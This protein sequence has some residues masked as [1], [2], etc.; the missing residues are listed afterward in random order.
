MGF[1]FEGMIEVVKALV[2]TDFHKSMTTHAD[3]RIWPDVYQPSTLAGQVYLK[4]TVI[5]PCSSCPLRS[6]EHEV[7]Y[8][9]CG[10]TGA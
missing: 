5:D 4:L 6:Y 2:S 10:R 7:P 3:Y 1:D 9:F 8:L